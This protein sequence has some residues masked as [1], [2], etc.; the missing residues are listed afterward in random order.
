MQDVEQKVSLRAVLVAL[1]SL[2]IAFGSAALTSRGASVVLYVLIGIVILAIAAL[3]LHRRP[4][5]WLSRVGGTGLARFLAVFL[6]LVGTA[7]FVLYPLAVGFV[8]K[9]GADVRTDFAVVAII[10]SLI[11]LANLAILVLNIIDLRR[12]RKPL[13]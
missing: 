12:S 8:A 5:G 3:G 6:P 2:G 11:A 4:L 9:V 1:L 10:S 7:I 13:R